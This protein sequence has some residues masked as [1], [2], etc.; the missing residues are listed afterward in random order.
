MDIP[1]YLKY[2]EEN[3]E[4]LNEAQ[5]QSLQTG[6]EDFIG[7]DINIHDLSGIALECNLLSINVFERKGVIDDI[8]NS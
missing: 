6:V 8:F 2:L 3:L 7:D 4:T 5:K 1:K